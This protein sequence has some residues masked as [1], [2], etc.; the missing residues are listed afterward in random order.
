MAVG[1]EKF[2]DFVSGSDDEVEDAIDDPD[3]FYTFSAAD[4]DALVA[5]L[6]ELL[7]S[8]TLSVVNVAPPG[9]WARPEFH[10]EGRTK[11]FSTMICRAD[12]LNCLIAIDDVLGLGFKVLLATD[13]LGEDEVAV[14]VLPTDFATE[15][16]VADKVRFDARLTELLAAFDH[17]N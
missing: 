14:T 3:M 17:F 9:E 16:R 1:L 12:L 13:L 2:R 5:A 15:L 4:F 6:N 7:P 10:C 11:S 8:S